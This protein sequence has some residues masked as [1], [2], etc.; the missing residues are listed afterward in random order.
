MF[1]LLF[2]ITYTPSDSKKDEAHYKLEYK[3]KKEGYFFNRSTKQAGTEIKIN[4]DRHKTLTEAGWDK[5]NW[6]HPFDLEAWRAQK[7]ATKSARKHA[8]A[9]TPE[10]P[11]RT[12]NV[13][14]GTGTV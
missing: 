11:P 14:T 12:S 4:G 1:L 7:E 2:L 3:Q 5:A 13:W 9:R 8:T 10:M 6:M